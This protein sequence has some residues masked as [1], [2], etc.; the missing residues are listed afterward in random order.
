M[1]MD[2]HGIHGYPWISMDSM[3]IH[4]HPWIS[5]ADRSPLY[6]SN[7]NAEI[8]P[9]R[10]DP[11]PHLRKDILTHNADSGLVMVDL[12]FWDDF[13]KQDRSW[14]DFGTTNSGI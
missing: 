3:D 10:L 11:C 9:S 8:D 7:F 6:I 2:I 4:G 5:A 14:D 12:A 13:F 1:S